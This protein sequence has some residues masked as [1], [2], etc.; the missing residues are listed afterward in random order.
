MFAFYRIGNEI[1][2]IREG[3]EEFLAKMWV[4]A[5]PLPEKEELKAA[6]RLTFLFSREP[7][8]CRDSFLVNDLKLLLQKEE[9]AAWLSSAELQKAADQVGDAPDPEETELLT[10]FME[11]GCL[12]AVNTARAGWK[13]ILAETRTWAPIF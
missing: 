10:E 2:F 5:R 6:E 13:E 11:R 7:G 3:Q 8:S 4:E 9:S 1:C 12:R